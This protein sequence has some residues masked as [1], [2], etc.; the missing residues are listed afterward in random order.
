MKPSVCVLVP[1]RERLE[2]AFMFNTW[3]PLYEARITLDFC[4]L[5]INRFLM[6]DMPHVSTARNGLVRM[7]L[8]RQPD[9]VYFLDA[10][11]V[12]EDSVGCLRILLETVKREDVD[13]VSGL[14]IDKRNM[15][16]C[17]KSALSTEL[18]YYR[19]NKEEE[20]FEVD[21]VG[22]GCALIDTKVFAKVP[23]PWFKCDSM[24]EPGED[25]YFC[26]KARENGFRVWVHPGV[27]FNH[28]GLFQLTPEGE[29][30]R[31]A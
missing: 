31:P 28:I 2:P 20:T 26:R 25:V 30:K 15:E 29:I 5:Y 16:P 17:F 7:A 19:G 23:Y 6:T 9:Y 21:A 8:N 4:T 3:L 14:Y 13:V 27:R 10:D 18:D 22:M 1:F 11:M 24:E 12:A